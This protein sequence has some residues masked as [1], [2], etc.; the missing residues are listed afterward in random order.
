MSSGGFCRP[1]SKKK[2]QKD[3]QIHGSCQKAEKS[4]EHKVNSDTNCSWCT[5]NGSQSFGKDIK[6]SNE[7]SRQSWSRRFGITQL[8]EKKI[9]SSSCYEKLTNV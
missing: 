8:Q 2:K 6:W 1:Q 4:A 5:W 3:G 9:I 7:E